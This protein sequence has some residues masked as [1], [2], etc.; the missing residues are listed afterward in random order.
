[1][2]YSCCDDLRRAAVRAHPELNGIDY[3]EVLDDPQL[4]NHQRQRKLL[5]HFLNDRGLAGLT[6]DNI[7]IRGGERIRDIS[8][9]EVVAGVGDE[10]HVLTV[11]V[12]SPGDFSRYTLD[13]VQNGSHGQP[14][15]EFDPL[16]SS[17]DFSFKVECPADFDCQV[18]H[19]CPPVSRTT[20]DIQ[21][22]AKDYASFRQLMLDRLA[23]LT[24]QWKERNAADIG[25][26]LVE[27]L[28]YVGDHLSYRQ[29]AIATEAYLGTARR[30]ISVRRHARLVDYHM[31]EGANARVWVQLWARADDIH[32]PQGTQFLSRVPRHGRHIPPP[33]NSRAYD[34][35]R[36]SHP[37]VFESMCPATLFQAHN[38]M[39]FYTWESRRCCL[40][41]GA[42][43]A[44][45]RGSFP[46][47]KPGDVLIFEEIIN[48]QTGQ[49]ADANAAH[50]HAVRLTHVLA[51]DRQNQPLT[52]RVNEEPITE[53]YWAMDDA[54]PF[55]LCVS[56][57]A[58]DAP[59]DVDVSVA[60][61]NVVLADHGRSVGPELIG[62]VPPVSLHRAR[63]TNA[64]HC[65]PPA[66]KP[67]GPR[68]CPSLREKPITFAVPYR[69][70]LLF[71]FNFQ[72]QLG[73]DLDNKVYSDELQRQLETGGVQLDQN[74]IVILGKFPE[75][76]LDDGDRTVIVRRE[77]QLLN[78]YD[79]PPSAAATINV[80]AEDAL[81]DRMRLESVVQNKSDGQPIA[82]PRVWLPKRDLIHTDRD[83][84]EFVVE[85]ES[86][87]SA[88]IRFGDD[89]HGMR[90][91]P[92]DV[93]TDHN[94]TAHYRVG[95]GP[96][97]NIGA[98]SLEHIVSTDTRIEKVR[99]PIAAH[100]GAAPEPMERVRQVA[101]QA[102]RR[103]ARAV[104][105]QDYAE[106]AQR[107]PDVQRAAAT[108]R[109][110]G[111]WYTV[112]LT[113][114]RI[115]GR[116]VDEPFERELRSH[117][118]Q[119]RMAG[120]DLEVDGPRYVPLEM[121]MHVCVR[122][123]YFRSTVEAAL[124]DV[125]SSRQLPDERH[126]VFHP[127]EFSFGQPVL[128][129]RIYSAA[130]SVPGVESVRITKFERQGSASDVAL[131]S[132]QLTFDRLEI[133]R[134]DNDPNFPDRGL[135]HLRLDG[136]K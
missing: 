83:K 22:L 4:P 87:G 5:V 93:L 110:T 88:H 85:V 92:G 123:E 75:W 10:A 96:D 120:Y 71:G 81:P 1:M 124:L 63:P 72:E 39:F 35:I 55:P 53:I 130:Q 16:L 47:L 133:A 116:P 14:P 15:A 36:A 69:P 34:E 73:T 11:E 76:S 46:N 41:K 29:D 91:L 64:D 113:V 50:R 52:D 24:P 38:E 27:L 60:R 32:V 70:K 18:K 79:L 67:V 23:V 102:F 45:L 121:E 111:S 95:N 94:F 126:G 57:K 19:V 136:G 105:P 61:G 59:G 12:S 117:L 6:K 128:L 114:D 42:T 8:V 82:K 56:I 62:T 77:D 31:H 80:R 25:M 30:R 101:P 58:Q 54:L 9:E 84:T 135:F 107:H 90:P 74:A 103:Q 104:T 3:L 129:S 43:H 66:R 131:K 106:C 20:P 28:A 109:W 134:L 2:I 68:F 127:D 89:E 115:G 108:F 65:K 122:P 26:T 99:N 100:G 33:P 132:G 86:D 97:G 17:V 49:K 112:F 78:V 37:V 21:Y 13:L 119:F 40:P 48:P 125:F 98:D 118:E 44:T 7:R 51:F